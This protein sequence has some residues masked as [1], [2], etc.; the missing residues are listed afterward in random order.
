MDVMRGSGLSWKK[1]LEELFGSAIA[2]GVTDLLNDRLLIA[3][4]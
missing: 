2:P 1:L 4:E 3:E